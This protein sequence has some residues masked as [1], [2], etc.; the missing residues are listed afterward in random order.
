MIW[1]LSPE[2]NTSLVSELL[3]RRHIKILEVGAVS[4][5]TVGGLVCQ[6][7]A[8]GEDQGLNIMAV[9][10]KRPGQDKNNDNTQEVK[11]S[12]SLLAI[13]IVSV[14]RTECTGY[15]GGHTN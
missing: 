4:A 13:T 12:L 5:Q 8:L 11:T 10:R 6:L 2:M 1:F 3:T 7:E 9:T 15:Y 14:L